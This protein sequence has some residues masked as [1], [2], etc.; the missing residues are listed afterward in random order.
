[1]FNML[2]FFPAATKPQT[3]AAAARQVQ[4]R[5]TLGAP[6]AAMTKEEAAKIVFVSSRTRLEPVSNL[7]ELFSNPSRTLPN[8]SD[9]VRNV[10]FGDG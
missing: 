2:N 3:S 5:R 7:S 10:V 9:P 1:M 8:P 6:A 4:K